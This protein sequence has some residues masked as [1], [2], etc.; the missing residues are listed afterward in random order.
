M[1]LLGIFGND[2]ENP[3]KDQVNRLEAALK[4]LGKNYD[5]PPLRRRRPR[6]LQRGA[7]SAYRPEQAADGWA[8]TFA[9]FH[10]HLG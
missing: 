5:I 2:D 9:F 10:K 1:P 4:K 7:R 3:N 6:L 8:K